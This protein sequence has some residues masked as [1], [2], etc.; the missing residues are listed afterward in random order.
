MSIELLTDN[1][2]ESVLNALGESQQRIYIVTPFI[3]KQPA[4]RLA[5][6]IQKNKVDCVLIS[7]FNYENF[8]TGVSD[9]DALIELHQAGAKVLAL[10][11]L[12]TKLYLID[13]CIVILG[14]ANFTNGGLQG[15]H[16]LSLIATDEY[17]LFQKCDEYF[18]DMRTA[19]EVAHEGIVT[20]EW[21]HTVK[22]SAAAL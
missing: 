14:S 18:A 10:K 7:R 15:N 5:Q 6:I 20:E 16:E 12:H 13:D 8:A 3:K 9:I 11:N 22:E 17:Q 4:H 2:R 21:L 1:H 19:I